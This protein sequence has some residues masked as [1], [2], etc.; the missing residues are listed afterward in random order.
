MGG[1]VEE[2]SVV[3]GLCRGADC[4]TLCLNAAV[5]SWPDLLH[6]YVVYWSTMFWD[7]DRSMIY[8][9]VFL[10]IHRT[11]FPVTFLL[12]IAA[13]YLSSCSIIS[14]TPEYDAACGISHRRACSESIKKAMQRSCEDVDVLCWISDIWAATTFLCIEMQFV[15]FV[16][17]LNLVRCR[18]HVHLDESIKRF[19][20]T[21]DMFYLSKHQ[22]CLGFFS[23]KDTKESR[24]V[25]H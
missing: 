9:P 23:Q 5:K 12:E 4:Y 18:W 10:F 25:V 1:N 16:W 21:S 8:R 17:F 7:P 6:F 20:E 2:A 24:V 22:L 19:Q 14:A 15:A 11:A 13:F 3:Q